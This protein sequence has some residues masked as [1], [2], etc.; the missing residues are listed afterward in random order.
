MRPMAEDELNNEGGSLEERTPAQ[1]EKREK[2]EQKRLEKQNREKLKVHQQAD[3]SPKAKKNNAGGKKAK[4]WFKDFRAE[5]KKIVWPDGKTVLKNTGIVIA[6]VIVIGI[7]VW[8]LDFGLS[9]GIMAL[10]NLA[11]GVSATEITTALPEEVTQAVT[12]AATA[13]SEAAVSTVRTVTTVATT[14]A[15]TLAP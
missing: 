10:K 13:A 12:E 7:L 3:K 4:K 6:T 11:A 8:I 9:N 2:E 15:T 1:L 5:L 14:V